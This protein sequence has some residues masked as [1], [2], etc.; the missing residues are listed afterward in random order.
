MGRLAVITIGQTPRTDLTP[1]LVDLIPVGTELL[2]LGA[3]DGLC[4]HEIAA[5]APASGDE[6]LTSR[7]RNGEAAV[8][9]RAHLIA[10]LQEL[11]HTAEA[12]ADVVMLACTGEFPAF[13]H[14]A[15][16]VEPDKVITEVVAEKANEYETI[17][18]ICPLEEQRI[19]AVRK[20]AVLAPSNARFISAVATPYVASTNALVAAVASLKDG[21]AQLLVLD[22]IGYTRTMA[23]LVEKETGL[24][25]L[26]SREVAGQ[27]AGKLLKK[28]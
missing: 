20:F 1:D 8:V 12:K 21:G 18:I 7:L 9:G 28:S 19:S 14:Q 11:I 3:L 2:E 5:M 6:V 4:A 24:P 27:A 25:V 22:C 10:R 23:A 16:L 17:G 13:V 26:L 15:P